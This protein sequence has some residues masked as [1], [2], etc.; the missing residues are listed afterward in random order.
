M[1]DTHSKHDADAQDKQA[2]KD[3]L[4]AKG[5]EAFDAEEFE[6]ALDFYHRATVLDGQDVNAWN[7]LG[8]TYYNLDFPR[9][10]W[11]SYKL[12]LHVDP[13]NLDSLWYAAEFL[14]NMEDYLLAKAF[15]T[16][17]IERETEPERLANAKSLL[18]DVELGIQKQQEEEPPDKDEELEEE[19]EDEQEQALK[20]ANITKLQKIPR[21]H[22]LIQMCNALE[23]PL[24]VAARHH[25]MEDRAVEG[26]PG[27]DLAAPHGRS[28]ERTTGAFS[29][30]QK[31]PSLG[32]GCRTVA[33]SCCVRPA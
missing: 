13:D 16:R 1:A 3:E 23:A 30:V 18:E 5:D 27:I 21:G 7:A 11:R 33:G 8:M 25:H 31:S 4:L 26:G 6:K 2:A 20:A 14:F 32:R 22:N 10:A 29:P 15:L 12:A 9:E 24:E 19:E 17:Y 28:Y